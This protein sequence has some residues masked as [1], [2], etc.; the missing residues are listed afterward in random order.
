MRMAVARRNE[1][2]DAITNEANSGKLR[3]YSGT[4][5][6]NA[7][8]AL[9][10]NTL[11]AELTMN[12]TSAGASS[13]GVWTA[14]AITS[15]ASA[16]ATGTATFARLFQSDGTTVIADFSVGTSGTEVIVAT[17]SIVAAA[18][19]SCSSMTVTYGVGA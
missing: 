13:G 11:L 5:P 1:M 15:D 3:L 7:D 18:V 16:D 14:N 2:L 17:T 10:G 9:S 12:A 6:T 19:V 8:T 4:R